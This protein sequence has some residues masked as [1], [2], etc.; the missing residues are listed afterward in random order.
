MVPPDFPGLPVF[1]PGRLSYGGGG[2]RRVARVERTRDQD[3]LAGHKGLRGS[4]KPAGD[5][6]LSDPR[7]ETHL[8]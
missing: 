8:H 5:R 2:H 4:R 7:M 3:G 1:S 6:R